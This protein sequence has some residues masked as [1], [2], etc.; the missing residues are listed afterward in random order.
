MM[1]SVV[2][3]WA[4]A[5]LVLAGA[6]GCGGPPAVSASD[7]EAR[8][9]GTVKIQGK[10]ATTGEIVFNPSNY[11]RTVPQRRAPIG[12][13]GSYS[14][15]TLVGGNTVT[16]AIPQNKKSKIKGLEYE[17]YSLDVKSGENSLDVEYPPGSN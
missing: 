11:Q 13:D 10:P 12:S 6:S 3:E 1:K 8:V 14:I 5:G 7:E 17:E 2:W 16:L 15:T 9:T 4:L